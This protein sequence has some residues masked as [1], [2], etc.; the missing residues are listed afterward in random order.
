MVDG[1]CLHNF[2]RRN[3][4]MLIKTS[5]P[6]RQIENML[7]KSIRRRH[8]ARRHDRDQGGLLTDARHIHAVA[9]PMPLTVV[10]GCP[11]HHAKPQPATI[12]NAG[13]RIASGYGRRNVQNDAHRNTF[14][15]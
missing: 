14:P 4:M 7:E 10:T 11:Q 13:N 3:T 5:D 1:Y 15:Q 8:L 9:A 6:V 2:T 12:P